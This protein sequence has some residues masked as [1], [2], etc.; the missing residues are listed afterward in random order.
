MHTRAENIHC[1][2][3]MLFKIDFEMKVRTRRFEENLFFGFQLREMRNFCFHHELISGKKN[4]FLVNRGVD[5]YFIDSGRWS[6]WWTK[7]KKTTIDLNEAPSNSVMS[8]CN[9]VNSIWYFFLPDNIM[10]FVKDSCTRRNSRCWFITLMMLRLWMG[11]IIFMIFF[12]ITTFAIT[13]NYRTGRSIFCGI[14]LLLLMCWWHFEYGFFFF[15]S[16]LLIQ[17]F[18]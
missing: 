17:S 16:S 15:F 14:C 10:P 8:R 4:K 13:V 12:A 5:F 18:I 6:R 9:Y 3:L 1:S 2:C 11:F 7:R